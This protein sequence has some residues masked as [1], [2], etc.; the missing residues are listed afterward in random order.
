MKI[1]NIILLIS[2]AI[3]ILT[4]KSKITVNTDSDTDA[5]SQVNEAEITEPASIKK[6][7]IKSG[8]ITFETDMMGIKEK[9]VLYFDD[10][11]MKEAEEEYEGEIVKET[12]L[13]DG[14]NMYDIITAD[15]AAYK[16][17]SCYRGIAY[18]FDWNE[19]SGEDQGTKAKKL[20]NMT[21]AD[22]DCESYSYDMGSTSTV[23]AGWKN[24]CLYQKTKSQMGAVVKKAIK[25][26]ENVSVP[27]AKL[28]VPSYYEIKKSGF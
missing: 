28:Q 5:I 20:P 10:Y 26:E 16:S 12:N 1:K 2:V 19:I 18:R 17:G 13:C 6:Y 22:K 3:L 25:I 15:K 23:Y 27:S 14:K 9:F 24:I 7:Q 8:I 11:G 21:I 4:C